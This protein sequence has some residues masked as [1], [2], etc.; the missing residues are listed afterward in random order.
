MSHYY[1]VI[2][3]RAYCMDA[4]PC[5]KHGTWSL[6]NSDSYVVFVSKKH[7]ILLCASV[8][9]DS[10]Y[11]PPLSQLRFLFTNELSA[12]GIVVL[13]SDQNIINVSHEKVE[14]KNANAIFE[15]N[16]LKSI[17]TK[18]AESW[19]HYIIQQ[20]TDASTNWLFGDRGT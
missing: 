14:I 6:C 19:P 15:K 20:A 3:C 9:R 12:F 16:E 2:M 17:E 1:K 11:L 13:C 7:N 4:G 10:Y 18:K 8:I 5:N